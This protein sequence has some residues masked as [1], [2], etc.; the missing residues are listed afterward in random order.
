[1]RTRLATLAAAT[2]ATLALVAGCGDPVAEDA[3]A[4]P[5]ESPSASAESSETASPTPT[6][7]PSETAPPTDLTTTLSTKQLSQGAPPAVPYL[8]ADNPAKPTDRWSLVRPAGESLGLRVTGP[9]GFA[10]MGNGLV[11]LVGDG[12]G[13]AASVVDGT[14]GEVT[15][16]EV[17]GYRLA[18]TSDRSIVAWLGSEGQTTVVEGGGARTFD[19]PEVEGGAELAAINGVGTCQEA[20]SEING[21]TAFVNKDEPRETY[22]TSSHG[23]TDLAGTMLSVS[24]ASADGPLVGLVSVTDE[25][26]CSGI[27]TSR[28]KP[29]WQT[30]DHT[31]TTFSP[32]ASRVLGTDAY[33]DGFG[34]RTVAFIDAEDGTVQHEFTSKGQGPTVLQTAWEDADHVLAVVYEKGRWSIVRLGVDGSAEL[35][36][37][38]L[39]GGDL[40]RPFVLEQD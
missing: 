32:D 26:S 22:L 36:V 28:G 10:T 23:I 39:V 12:D 33:L 2:A 16:E 9:F 18:V 11:L 5:T 40:D 27:Y 1:M 3:D 35:A 17:R 38:P 24:D 7:D 14:G 4:D 8:A 29:K 31:L 30:C 20:E 34:Q 6:E 13:A 21:C 19:L 37:G 15:R 25:G